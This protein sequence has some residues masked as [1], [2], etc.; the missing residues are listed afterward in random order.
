MN[1]I[2]QIE[3]LEVQ[4][5]LPKFPYCL[6]HYSLPSYFLGLLFYSSAA[7]CNGTQLNCLNET[8]QFSQ[9]SSLYSY[10][11]QSKY[12]VRQSKCLILESLIP[13]FI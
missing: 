7:G 8:L 1:L 11:V 3:K 4:K 2:A 10:Y 6:L 5:Y 13:K 9:N 12:E